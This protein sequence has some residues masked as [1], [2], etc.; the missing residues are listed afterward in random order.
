MDN[1]NLIKV[2]V[3]GS[4]SD[5]NVL[6]V[7]RNIGRGEDIACQVFN[8]GFCP[9]V[10]WFDKEFVI[11]YWRYEFSVDAFYKYSLEWLKVSDCML[12]VPNVPGLKNWEESS[13][14]C[15]EIEVAE[16]L[17]IPV[18][19]SVTQMVKHYGK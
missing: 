19:Y 9:F 3:A 7:L 17:G 11:R 18:F 8:L 2:Y 6:G 5:V 10:P 15:K 4:Y 14:T 16:S 12:V 13:G 1:N